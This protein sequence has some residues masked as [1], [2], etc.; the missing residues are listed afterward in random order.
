MAKF[1][2]SIKGIPAKAEGEIDSKN[3]ADVVKTGIS[4]V[5]D[6]AYKGI[7]TVKE[8]IVK[9]TDDLKETSDTRHQ[10]KVEIEQLKLQKDQQEHLQKM[11]IKESKQNKK[12]LF[13][14]WSDY[15]LKK[16]E[17]KLKEKQLNEEIAMKERERQEVAA[18][19]E[20]ILN[21]VGIIA[22]IF[23]S[24][25]FILLIIKVIK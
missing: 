7:D 18:R 4:S 16:E 19:K 10:H 12:G 3:T 2:L 15:Q 20:R 9:V 22:I 5:K 11:E 8:T 14:K 23:A 13:D 6:V 21:F 1:N 17:L 25:I 24:L